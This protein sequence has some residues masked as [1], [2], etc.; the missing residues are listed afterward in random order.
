MMLTCYADAAVFDTYAVMPILLCCRV[1]HDMLRHA[2]LDA[3]Y[4]VEACQLLS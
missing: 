1:N 3:F 4:I 2:M